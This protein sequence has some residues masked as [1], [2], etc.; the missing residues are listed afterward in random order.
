MDVAAAPSSDTTVTVSV[1]VVMSP[2]SSPFL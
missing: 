1:F 2:P